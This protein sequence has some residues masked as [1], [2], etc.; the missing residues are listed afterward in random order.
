MASKQPFNI[1][2]VVLIVGIVGLSFLLVYIIWEPGRML[3]QMEDFK[4]ESR[5]RM[6]AI[7]I[8]EQQYYGRYETYTANMDSLVYFVQQEMTAAQRDSLFPKLYLYA[9]NADSMRFAPMSRATYELAIDDTT[10]IPRWM[11][12][13]PDGFG[14]ISSL[15][16]PDEHNKASWEQ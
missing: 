16:N 12:T 3:A 2:D 13:D 6:N 1:I 10:S 4:W 9:F 15:T 5:A 11:V 8:A 7:R 14:Y